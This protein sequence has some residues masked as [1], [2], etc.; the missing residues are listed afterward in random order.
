MTKNDFNVKL[1][2]NELSITGKNQVLKETN[3]LPPKEQALRF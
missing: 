3:R 2:G 1:V